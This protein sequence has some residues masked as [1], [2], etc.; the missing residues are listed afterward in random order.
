M[1]TFFVA[2]MHAWMRLTWRSA[3]AGLL[4]FALIGVTMA[5]VSPQS[6][7]VGPVIVVC[8]VL[9]AFAQ[10]V[11]LQRWVFRKP[12]R[13]PEGLVELCV[14]RDGGPESHPLAPGIGWALWW[15]MT[16]RS[17][18]LL[19]ACAVP[20]AAAALA[21]DLDPDVDT[22]LARLETAVGFITSIL[23]LVWLLRW[24]Y[25]ATRISIRPHAEPAPLADAVD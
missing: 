2:A 21:F 9:L 12:F 17:V 3:L 11:I 13:A 5:L 24:Q 1:A 6:P 10:V 7:I 4:L 23:G 16:W 18:V 8:V 14:E 25:G 20:I 22:W 15:G 19:L